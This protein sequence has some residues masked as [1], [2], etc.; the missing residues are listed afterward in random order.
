MKTELPQKQLEKLLSRIRIMSEFLESELKFILDMKNLVN[1]WQP[2][3]VERNIITLKKSTRIFQDIPLLIDSH[4]K[5][6]NNFP[7][8]HEIS[9]EIGQVFLSFGNFFQNVNIS[10]SILK[11]I[12]FLFKKISLILLLTNLHP[13]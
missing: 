9:T 11:V 10:I 13:V 6:V 4:Q 3:L 12:K 2:M 7:P 1:F 5:F 8:N